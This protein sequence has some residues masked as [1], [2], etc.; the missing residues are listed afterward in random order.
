MAEAVPSFLTE[1]KRLEVKAKAQTVLIENSLKGLTDIFEIIEDKAFLIKRP[2]THSDG[3]A[4]FSGFCTYMLNKY[5]VF[6][7]TAYSQG[8]QR[9]TAAHELYHVYFD[10]EDLKKARLLENDGNKSESENL[11][12][13][14]AAELLMPED[15]LKEAFHLE[16]KDGSFDVNEAIRMNNKFKVSYKAILMRCLQLKLISLEVFNDLAQ[17][18]SLEKKQELQDLTRDNGYN[19]NLLIPTNEISVSRKFV[20]FAFDNF[21]DG[22]I[23]ES[24]FRSILEFAGIPNVDEVVAHIKPEDGNL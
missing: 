13:G 5:V 10:S 17:Y 23:S 14:F 15:R 24:R 21:K 6:I 7:N 9:Y 2:Y 4:K 12:Q 19:I 18:G 1:E 22:K 3:K 20:D 11:A 8:H 16:T